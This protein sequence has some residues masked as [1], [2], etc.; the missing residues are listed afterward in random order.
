MYFKIIRFSKLCFDLDLPFT[1]G[2][3]A[4]VWLMYRINIGEQVTWC[5][6]EQNHPINI[7]E[8]PVSTVDLTKHLRQQISRL[9]FL[10]GLLTLVRKCQQ[11]GQNLRWAALTKTCFMSVYHKLMLICPGIIQLRKRFWMDF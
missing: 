10:G 4:W 9:I 5:T 11:D 6:L 1:P 2:F 7:A 3:K 8:S